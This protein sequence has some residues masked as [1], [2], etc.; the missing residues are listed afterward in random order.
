MLFKERDLEYKKICP[1]VHIGAGEKKKPTDYAEKETEEKNK[2]ACY[3]K[4][5]KVQLL[6]YTWIEMPVED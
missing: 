1:R 4:S 6:Q 5:Y 3:L 2:S